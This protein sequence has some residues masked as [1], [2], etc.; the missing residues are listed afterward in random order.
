MEVVKGKVLKKEVKE[1]DDVEIEGK[2]SIVEKRERG[3]K[4]REG[5]MGRE[6]RE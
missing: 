6:I 3:R 2:E 4:G 5:E 1:E